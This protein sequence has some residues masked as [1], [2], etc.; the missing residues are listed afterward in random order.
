MNSDWII[1]EWS[2]PPRVKSLITTRNGGVSSGPYASLNLGLRTGDDEAAVQA[3]RQRLRSWLP[4][5]PRWLRQV[6]AAKVVDTD[7]LSGIPEADASI[8]RT[9]G[10]VCAV[11][12]ADCM[13]V[14]LSDRAGSVIGI[15]HAGWRGLSAGVIENTVRAMQVCP[16]D[17]LAYLG[18]AIGRD[19][20]EVGEDVRSAF[21]ATDAAAG[22]AFRPH[23]A[24]KWLADLGML[25]RQRLAACGVHR[26][27]GGG[28][29]TYR[30]AA[31]Y[32]SYRRDTITGRMAALLW[33][34]DV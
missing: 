28:E 24:S 21:L 15:A 14:L 12:V 27:F 11:L 5:E 23:R 20:F 31:R 30:D 25:A 34:A 10:T 7:D 29:C 1:P 33:I 26:V 19:A 3:N 13:P 32:Y 4:G 18:P 22:A 17:L 6:H 8:A 16:A 9:P 2:V